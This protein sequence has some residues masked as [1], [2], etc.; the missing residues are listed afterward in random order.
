MGDTELGHLVAVDD[1]HCVVCLIDED[2]YVR[3]RRW[4]AEDHET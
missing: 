4:P 2:R 3:L 1:I